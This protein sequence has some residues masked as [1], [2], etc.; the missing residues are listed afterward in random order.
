[1]LFLGNNTEKIVL[2]RNLASGYT[3]LVY[4][5]KDVKVNKQGRAG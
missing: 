5:K 1:M 4:K 3:Q 2:G